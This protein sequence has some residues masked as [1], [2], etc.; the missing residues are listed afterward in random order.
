MTAAQKAAWL[1]LAEDWM[2]LARD[3][4]E[5]DEAESDDDEIRTSSKSN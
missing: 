1:E 5:A 2:R 3:A 4:K